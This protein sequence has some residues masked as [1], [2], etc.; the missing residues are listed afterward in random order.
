MEIEKMNLKHLI[1]ILLGLIGFYG[2]YYFVP[3]QKKLVSPIEISPEIKTLQTSFKNHI[4]D[5]AKKVWQALSSIG[6]TEERCRIVNKQR[7]ELYTKE[8]E[9]AFCKPEG[10]ISNKTKTMI[11]Q[12]MLEFGVEPTD[13]TVIATTKMLGTANACDKLLMVNE[14]NFSYFSEPAQKFIIGHEVQHIL[15]KDHSTCSVIRNLLPAQEKEQLMLPRQHPLMQFYRFKEERADIGAAIKNEEWAN[16]YLAYTKEMMEI[17][18]NVDRPTHPKSSDRLNM[19]QNI[20]DT[21]NT[22]IV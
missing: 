3:V 19:A 6:I 18:G 21:I 12:V 11:N 16:N 7:Y 17:Y 13:I 14:K 4:A 5:N 9:K 22:K 10:E 1:I 2:M 20:V 8:T 15:N